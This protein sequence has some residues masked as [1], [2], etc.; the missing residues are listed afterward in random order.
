MGDAGNLLA[1]GYS[2]EACRKALAKMVITDELPFRT[3]D[4]EVLGNFA[5]L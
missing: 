1:I 2:K 4:G 3:M 5:K